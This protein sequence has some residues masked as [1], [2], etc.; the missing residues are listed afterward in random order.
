[1]LLILKG[2]NYK[3]HQEKKCLHP[4]VQ[5]KWHIII[6]YNAIQHKFYIL[7]RVFLDCLSRDLQIFFFF[8]LINVR[9]GG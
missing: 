8:F 2:N 3:I 6:I 9:V 1:M 5:I 7:M 4:T